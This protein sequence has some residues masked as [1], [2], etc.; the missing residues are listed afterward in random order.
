[1]D[2]KAYGLRYG[3][4]APAHRRAGRSAYGISARPNRHAKRP[5]SAGR[6]RGPG[7]PDGSHRGPGFSPFDVSIEDATAAGVR[8]TGRRFGVLVHALLA[9]VPVDAAASQVRD[10]ATLHARVLG[11]PDNE[12]D[13]ASTAVERA[14]QHRLLAEAR[15]AQRAGRACRREAPISIVRDGV[16]IDGQIDLAFDNGSGWTVVDFKTD[17]ELG[18]SEAD[19]RRQV[20]LYADALTDITGRPAS[21]TILR[22]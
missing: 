3:R 19:Y 22:V 12:R 9:A 20:A 16:L 10:L 4:W 17:A 8:P 6:C 14:L 18:V 15:E 7:I 11:A 21:A 13:A 1:M 2:L 5:A